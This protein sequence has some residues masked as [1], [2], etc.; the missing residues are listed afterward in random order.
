MLV[1]HISLSLAG[2]KVLFQEYLM[3]LRIL[4]FPECEFM[5]HCF[6]KCYTL[7]RICFSL[8]QV[9][10]KWFQINHAI[11]CSFRF[12]SAINGFTLTRCNFMYFHAIICRI[13]EAKNIHICFSTYFSIDRKR[14]SH[15][16]LHL[17]FTPKGQLYQ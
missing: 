3:S 6:I 11:S 8:R 16:F 7:K 5:R 10:I 2:L 14:N 4:M 13:R 9:N 17:F 15:L 12:W 1:S